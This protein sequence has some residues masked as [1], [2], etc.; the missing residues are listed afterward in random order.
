MYSLEVFER[1]SRVET[2]ND[3]NAEK[4]KKDIFDRERCKYH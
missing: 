3:V 4:I 2:I 1:E